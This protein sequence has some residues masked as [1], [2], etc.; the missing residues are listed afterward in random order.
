MSRLETLIF[1]SH[2]WEVILLIYLKNVSLFYN[3]EY[4]S[5]YVVEFG[6]KK[7]ILMTTVHIDEVIIKVFYTLFW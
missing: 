1:R 3:A 5:T 7:G 6:G 4:S 2:P